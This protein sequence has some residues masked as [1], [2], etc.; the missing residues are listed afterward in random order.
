M[1]RVSKKISAVKNAAAESD[2]ASVLA[3]FDEA[4]DIAAYNSTDNGSGMKH[5]ALNQLYIVR[6]YIDR[7]NNLQDK[8]L[9]TD[10]SGVHGLRIYSG[11]FQYKGA[12]GKWHDVVLGGDGTGGTGVVSPDIANAEVADDKDVSDLFG[13]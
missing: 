6:D 5:V 8:K 7:K 10:E 9:I 4:N 12:D 3:A 13:I 1:A 2:T 11:K